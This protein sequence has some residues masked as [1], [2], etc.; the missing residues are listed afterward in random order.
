MFGFNLDKFQFDFY[1]LKKDFDDVISALDKYLSNLHKIKDTPQKQAYVLKLVLSCSTRKNTGVNYFK[2][3]FPDNLCE[4]LAKVFK[5]YD[6]FDEPEL[7]TAISHCIDKELSKVDL[8]ALIQSLK[9]QLQFTEP[10]LNINEKGSG[11]Q[12]V[13]LDRPLEELLETLELIKYY[14]QKLTYDDV[15]KLTSELLQ[16]TRNE[17]T[18]LPE[19]PWFFM[20]HIIGLDGDTRENCHRSITKISQESDNS[21]DKT[22]ISADDEDDDNDNVDGEDGFVTNDST[23]SVHP[24]DMVYAIFFMCR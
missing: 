17:L 9:T 6:I 12:T 21:D 16:E 2:K 24:L 23:L 1:L 4:S 7:Q 20:K 5:D 19:L 3:R 13:N 11:F 10:Q 14:P 22:I 18:S 8:K 15:T